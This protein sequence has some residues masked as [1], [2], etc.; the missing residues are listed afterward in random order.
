M[1]KFYMSFVHLHTH[2]HYSLLDGLV[3]I[4]DLIKE[5]VRYEMPALALTDH[6][7]LYGA[8]EFYKKAKAAGIKPIIGVEAYV[9][10]G[11]RLSKKTG[12]DEKRYHL[13]ILAENSEG[14]Q[15]LLKLASASYLD[16]FYYK[17]RVDKELL[18]KFSK[19][20]I[21][22]SSCLSGEIA[23]TLYTHNR[24]KAGQ[25]LAEYRDIF[26]KDNFFIELSHHPGIPNHAEIQKALLD[27]ARE[28]KTPIIA[29]QDIHYLTKED[30][31]AQ[32]VL[33]AVQTNTRLDDP[34][35]LTMKN[36]D[37]SMLS[38]EE[39]KSHFRQ[40]P[41]AIAN[42]LEIADRINFKLEL[43]KLSFPYFDIPKEETADSYLAKL[44]RQGIPVRYGSQPAAEILK[45]FEYELAVIKKT[46]FASYFLIVAD[47]VNWAKKNGI[48]VGPGRGSVAG[49]LL[50]YL[51]NITNID[52]IKY[53]LLFERFMNPER[54]SP[55]D[56]D[57]DFAD[58]RRNEVLEYVSRKFGEDHVAQIITFGTMAARA[59]VRDAGRAIGQ[60]YNFCD[61]LAKMIPFGNSLKESLDSN[62]EFKK[63]YETN[64]DAKKIIDAAVKLE[65]VAR[66]A[67]VHACG[68]V[69]TPEPLVESVPLQ[70][71]A[72]AQN[73]NEKIVI[74]QYEMRSI[75]DLGLLK[76]DILGLK[77]LSIIERAIK[78]VKERSGKEI[79]IDSIP[80]DDSEVFKM[81]AEGKTAGVFQL[82][83]GGMTRYLIE[84]KPTILEDII[85][86]I[87]LF[88]PGPIEL[89]PR[90]IARKQGREKITYLHPKMA[91]I[92][93]STYGV[94]TYQ[95]QL[96]QVARDIAGF[97]LAEAD[98]LRKAV[99]KKI[100]ILLDEQ[101]EKFI[102]GVEK[103][104]GQRRLGEKIWE[105]IEPF[106]RYGFNKSHSSGYAL[107]AYQTAWLKCRYPLEFMSALMN[108]DEKDNERIAFLVEEAKKLGIKVLPPDIN[109]SQ[110]SFTP[111]EANPLSADQSAE[112]TIRFGLRAIKNVGAGV[113]SAIIEERKINGP[114]SNLADLLERA[115]SKDLNKKSLESLV[116]A[117]ALD[118]VG[119]RNQMLANMEIILAYRKDAALTRTQ[120]QS[121]LFG[122]MNQ[123][124]IPRLKLQKADPAAFDEK[125]KWEKELL[126]LYISGHPLDKMRLKLEKE[127]MNINTAKALAEGAPAMIAG[128]VQSI[129][130]I[131]TKK[132]EPMAFLKIL[133]FSGSLEA[134]VF[135]RAL[136]K[137]G[138]LIREETG[139][140]I[141]GRIS[142]RNNQASIIAN[143]IRTL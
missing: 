141:K 9:A 71:A 47:I 79:D 96:M 143:E 26:G 103:T 2:S 119:E 78:L 133:D 14:Y 104:S 126:G 132:G 20:L 127:K 111:L 55:P 41:D 28:T 88:R 24:Q 44:C 5:V 34:D 123:D 69:I 107:V 53:N 16:G 60:S 83:G 84:L 77:N 122:L 95:E 32:D 140:K 128:C 106:A 138:H 76:M 142:R 81:L 118:G 129:K 33:L 105:Q 23:R 100:K 139:L 54:V 59:A 86:M 46:G 74:T 21:A 3:K 37:F 134:L 43:G 68:V 91:P 31:K 124:S 19:G 40:L 65:G 73:Q 10:S 89:I 92:L 116:K 109:L 4:D 6:G 137:F 108:A 66:H 11:S 117:G 130:K 80:L 102:S 13:I 45:R 64:P 114:Y 27:L 17:P 38:P 29:A 135:P 115:A 57:L 36:D 7:N 97:T 8:V 90:Y 1:L 35:R 48:L 56:I 63:S 39:M 72:R 113:V 58:T 61:Q 94:M 12:I 25:I 101:K 42:T 62:L 93:E 121:S 82:E 85:A 98:I 136:E 15:N 110:E 18:R 131:L 22:T 30:A 87:S 120:N 52:P 67:S 50:A 49:S 125:I 99:G 112:A 70:Y 75:E 51:L